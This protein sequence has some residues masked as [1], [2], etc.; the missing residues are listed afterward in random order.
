VGKRKD[1]KK[2]PNRGLPEINTRR[3]VEKLRNKKQNKKDFKR[4]EFKEKDDE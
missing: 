1:V 3:R 2:F 4:R